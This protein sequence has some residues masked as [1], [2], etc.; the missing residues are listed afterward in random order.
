MRIV[1]TGY[2]RAAISIDD[3]RCV[4]DQRGDVVAITDAYN[5]TIAHGEGFGARVLL[6]N[7]DDMSVQHDQFGQR[8]VGAACKSAA[9][10]LNRGGHQ[11]GDL[12]YSYC[13]VSPFP[14]VIAAQRLLCRICRL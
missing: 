9:K 14:L 4:T 11:Q 1:K 2:D 13:S 3:L 10:Q 5:A 6:V 8:V 7:G 12:G